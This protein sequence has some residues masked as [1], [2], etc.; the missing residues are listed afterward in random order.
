MLF[1]YVC[2]FCQGFEPC[3]RESV[4]VCTKLHAFVCM[5]VCVSIVK[6]VV[7]VTHY[8]SIKKLKLIKIKTVHRLL[9]LSSLIFTSLTTTWRLHYLCL[10]LHNTHMFFFLLL[11][12]FNL[13]FVCLFHWQ[14]YKRFP[15]FLF[16]LHVFTSLYGGVS[17]R[18]IPFSLL[19]SFTLSL[20]R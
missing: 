7:V 18:V 10:F 6:F 12:H 9:R 15:L 1:V 4:C 3:A 14:G 19:F 16:V 20:L 2:V 8:P 17:L 13:F 5:C 11:L